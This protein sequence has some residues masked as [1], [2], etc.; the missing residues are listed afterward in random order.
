MLHLFGVVQHREIYSAY[1]T[2]NNQFDVKYAILMLNVREV[3]IRFLPGQTGIDVP[4][5][6]Q[7]FCSFVPI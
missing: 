1:L 4:S 3:I 5:E 7:P 6:E 2:S